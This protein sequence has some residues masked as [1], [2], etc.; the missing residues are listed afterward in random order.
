MLGSGQTDWLF[1]AHDTKSR[2]ESARPTTAS[3]HT[4]GEDGV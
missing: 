3:S 2:A 1:D 4:D